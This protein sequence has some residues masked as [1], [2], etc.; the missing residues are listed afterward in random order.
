[1]ACVGIDLGGTKILALLVDGG[2]VVEKYKQPTPRND[3]PETILDAIAATARE[4]DPD[5]RASRIGLGVPGPLPAG[6]GILP[7]ASNLFGWNR[8]V[9][10][11][12]ELSERLDGRPVIVDN[13]CNLAT[14]AEHQLGA[15]RGVDN[16]LGVFLGTGVGAGLILDGKLRRGPHGLAGEIGHTFVDFRAIRV[17]PDSGETST[18]N[19]QRGELE[20]YAGRNALEQQARKMHNQGMPSMLIERA[21]EAPLKSKLWKEA[22]DANDRVARQLIDQAADALSAAIANVVNLVDIQLVVLGGGLASR[23]GEEFRQSIAAGLAARAYGNA[24]VPIREAAFGAKSGAT[25]A[26]LLAEEQPA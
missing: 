24:H 4:V 7:F 12:Q 25:G 18:L 10:V 9:D 20:E 17:C 6:S 3:P 14:L 16:C 21:G 5:A 19:G 8:S 13:D 22:L 1:M 15:A 23:L 11:A 2:E 26:A